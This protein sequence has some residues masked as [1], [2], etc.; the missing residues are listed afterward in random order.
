MTHS[1]IQ[2]VNSETLILVSG[3]WTLA[4]VLAGTPRLQGTTVDPFQDAVPCFIMNNSDRW[5]GWG[6]RSRWEPDYK[7]DDE[8]QD[9]RRRNRERLRR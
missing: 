3:G 8:R 5:D 9:A 6:E 7:N 1:T 2:H 4:A